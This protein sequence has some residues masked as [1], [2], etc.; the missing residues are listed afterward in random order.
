MDDLLAGL[1]IPLDF[2]AT[3]DDPHRLDAVQVVGTDPLRR[4]MLQDP[5]GMRRAR[6]GVQ[7]FAG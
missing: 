5:I 4:L 2:D 6:R 3:V 1:G 7:Q